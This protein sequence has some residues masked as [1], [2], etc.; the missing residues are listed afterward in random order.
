M[1]ER[2]FELLRLVVASRG[3]TVLLVEQHVADALD[4]AHRA[5]FVERRRIA[6]TGTGAALLQNSDVQRAYTGL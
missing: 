6:K 2:A 5:S 1:A 3:H 4:I